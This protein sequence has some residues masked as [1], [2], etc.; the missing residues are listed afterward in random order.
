MAFQILQI[1]GHHEEKRQQSIIYKPTTSGET[2]SW[3]LIIKAGTPALRS[4]RLL[5]LDL[6]V[7]NTLHGLL[8]CPIK[9]IADEPCSCFNWNL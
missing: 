6:V 9:D 1:D 7:E 5:L 3:L 8:K 4:Q 2:S